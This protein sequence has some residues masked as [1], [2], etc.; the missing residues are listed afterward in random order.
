MEH[1]KVEISSIQEVIVEVTDAQIRELNDL[2]LAFVG[3][4]IGEVIAS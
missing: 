2:Q 4:G 1:T 3:G